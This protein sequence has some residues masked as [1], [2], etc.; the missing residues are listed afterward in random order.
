MSSRKAGAKRRAFNLFSVLAL[1]AA[2]AVSVSGAGA[3]GGCGEPLGTGT[4]T[5]AIGDGVPDISKVVVATYEGGTTQFQIS[6]PGVD[7]FGTDML[8]RTLVDSDKNA[9]T[10]NE[11][12]YE[13]MIQSIS[14]RA[15]YGSKGVLSA[16]CYAA[17]STLYAW[18][19]SAWVKQEDETLNT[20][21]S[22]ETLAL[23]LNSSELGNAVTFDLAVYAAA[24]V[25]YSESGEPELSS[26]TS[27]R[28]PDK[29]SYAYK[30]FEW[31]SYTDAADD[32]SA[33]GAPDIT[34][35]EVMRKSGQIK[36]T[37][38][39]PGTY[40]FNDDMLLRVLIDSDSNAA[41]GDG[42][43]FEY[44]LQ[45]QR[46]S[47]GKAS[48]MGT[49]SVL[50]ALCTQPSVTLFQWSEGSWSAVEDD[51]L[52]WW[53]EYG[54]TLTL[55]SAAIGNPATFNFAVYVA[56]KVTFDEAGWP[57][58]TPEPAFDRAPDTG[59]LA[60]PLV[61][62]NAEL[63]GEYKVTS[64]VIKSTG[65]LKPAKIS[66]KTWSFQ[67]SCSKKKCNT[68][69][70]IKGQGK[71][72]LSRAGKTS[73]KAQAGGKKISCRSSVAA[74]TTQTFSMNVKQGALVK[75]KWRVT[76]WVGTLKVSAKKKACGSY[77]AA[78]TGTLKK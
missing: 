72:K 34:G 54:A 26:A 47:Y 13:Y 35:V 55:D 44:M 40:E 74:R 68:N 24:G 49:K 12:G 78:L 46:A 57:N 36:F 73:Y 59:S 9:A 5:D 61:V 67:K 69:V 77:T 62:S 3:T 63:V 66:K 25:T 53:F 16:K 51:L 58:L 32:G 38:T 27:D 17:V 52:K 22:D 8:V 4:F 41:T 50:R 60:F 71:V 39:I 21:Y 14:E 28:A 33:E 30:P 23:K 37:V 1:T 6:L 76:K 18:S 7:E 65:N 2:L 64:K 45:G 11:E 15:K 42:N 29:G 56:S 75:G 10:G 20:R 43:G 31:N 48:L 19:G 70:K